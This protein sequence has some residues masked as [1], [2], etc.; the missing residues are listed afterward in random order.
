MS[1][2][3]V[4]NVILLFLDPKLADDLEIVIPCIGITL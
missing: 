2:V 1:P 3:E 4:Q